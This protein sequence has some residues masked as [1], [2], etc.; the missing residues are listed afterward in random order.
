MPL[1][2]VLGAV[3]QVRCRLP[4]TLLDSCLGRLPLQRQEQEQVLLLVSLLVSLL[5]LLPVLLLVLLLV[6]F[7]VLRCRRQRNLS[8]EAFPKMQQ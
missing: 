1:Q 7:P 5:V 6:L 3:H 8:T 2:E 4:S